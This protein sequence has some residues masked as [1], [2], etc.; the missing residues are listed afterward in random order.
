MPAPS[1]NEIEAMANGALSGAGL[2]GERAPDL[3]GAMGQVIGQALAIFAAMGMVAPG[4]PAAVDPVSGAGSTAGPGMLLPPPSGG[5]GAG[6]I[7]PLAKAALASKRLD[8][9]QKGA[10]AK[11]LA[12]STAQAIFLFTAAVQVA[13]GIAIAGFVTAAPGSLVGAA[14]SKPM[15]EPIALG[16]ENAQRLSGQNAPG[17]ASAIAETLA[18][19]LSALV[20]RV[21]VAPGIACAPAATISPGR[22]I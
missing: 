18:N 8:G 7:E 5:P 4:I 11:V 19:A 14:P 1:A 16:F 20:T 10:L 9:E 3:A 15:L 13:P 2:R 12:Q 6:Q 22:L 21:R 17:L